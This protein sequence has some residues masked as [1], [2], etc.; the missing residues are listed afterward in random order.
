MKHMKNNNQ[1]HLTYPSS[2]THLHC[3]SRQKHMVNFFEAIKCLKI[4]G[5]RGSMLGNRPE[6][7]QGPME[8]SCIAEVWHCIIWGE[9]PLGGALWLPFLSEAPHES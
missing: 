3:L 1:P 4:K 9:K 8:A 7:L 2:L 5:P 6:E